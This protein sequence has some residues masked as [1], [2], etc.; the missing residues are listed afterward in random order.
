MTALEERLAGRLKRV[1]KLFG[2]LRS[3]RYALFD[4]AFQEELAAMYRRSG[5]KTPVPP[6]QLAM[7]ILLQAY[8]G[9]SDA[10]AVELTVVD[11]RWQS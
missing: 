8:V 1:R 5:G 7:V 10:E 4:A 2:F 11:L 6:A 9:A 3:H